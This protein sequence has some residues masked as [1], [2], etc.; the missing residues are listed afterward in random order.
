MSLPHFVVHHQQCENCN[1]K[2]Y[3]GQTCIKHEDGYFC[4]NACLKIHLYHM[5]GAEEVYLTDDR[6][7]REVN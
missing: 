1:D 2:L 3:I 5:S 6:I 7:F 4:T